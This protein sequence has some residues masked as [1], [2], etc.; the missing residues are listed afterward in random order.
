MNVENLGPI[1]LTSVVH[2]G[3]G[4]TLLLNLLARRI[5]SGERSGKVLV[6]GHKLSKDAFRSVSAYVMQEDTLL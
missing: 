1:W 6:N 4:K 5:K 3:A 2:T